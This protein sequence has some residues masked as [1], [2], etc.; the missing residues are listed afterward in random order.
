M[1]HLSCSIT[2]VVWLKQTS[3]RALAHNTTQ[4]Y[5]KLVRL[6]CSSLMLIILIVKLLGVIVEGGRG[7]EAGWE[8]GGQGWGTKL[9]GCH[10]E[11]EVIY[12]DAELKCQQQTNASKSSYN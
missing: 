9:R 11:D 4:L 10:I 2:G 8:G 3:R 12:Y 1:I 7:G 5:Y 6:V